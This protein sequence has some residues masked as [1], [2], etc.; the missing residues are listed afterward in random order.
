MR[1]RLQFLHKRLGEKLWVRPLSFC[2]L[3]VLAA[4]AASAADSLRLRD[5]VPKVEHD[6]VD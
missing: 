3:A 4:F 6:T 2:I 1:S 5:L